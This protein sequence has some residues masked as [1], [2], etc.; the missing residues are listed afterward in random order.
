MREY[1]KYIIIFIIFILNL[2]ELSAQFAKFDPDQNYNIG[3]DIIQIKS[4]NSIIK[5]KQK[6]SSVVMENS[7][8]L[9]KYKAVI[10]SPLVGN[11]LYAYP[12][13]PMPAKNYVNILLYWDTKL[14]IKTAEMGVYDMNG[15]KR[16]GKE[17]IT[18]DQ[19]SASNGIITW[20][21]SGFE[22]GIYFIQIKHGTE[23]SNVKV[24]IE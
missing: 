6:H 11:Y 23:T 22:R 3:R 9:S 18:L 20:C 4:K 2:I 15:K 13:Y 17:K 5:L 19:Q 16:C 12:P 21:S 24:I 14:D 7:N 10:E 1:F 8:E